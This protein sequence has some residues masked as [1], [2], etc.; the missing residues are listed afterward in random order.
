VFGCGASRLG[1]VEVFALP[2][3]WSCTC[4]MLAGGLVGDAGR[5]GEWGPT[6]AAHQG[7]RLHLIFAAFDLAEGLQWLLCSLAWV[8]VPLVGEAL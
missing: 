6:A 1:L 3:V 8:G 2:P 4:C 5:D 7:S